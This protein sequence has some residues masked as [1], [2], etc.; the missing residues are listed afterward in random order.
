MRD[1]CPKEEVV[2]VAVEADPK[3]VMMMTAWGLR[4]RCE[5]TRGNQEHTSA[6]GL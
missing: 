2:V 4:T 5:T 6:E 1:S 3:S